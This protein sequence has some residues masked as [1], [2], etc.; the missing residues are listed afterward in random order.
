MVTFTCPKC[1]AALPVKPGTQLAVCS[2][3][4]TPSYIDRR[5]ALFFYILPFAIEETA[6]R[7]IF[8]RWTAGPACPKDMEASAS[9]LS[10]KKEYFPVFRF[11]RTVDGKEQVFSRPARGTL[12]PGMQ[13]VVIPPGDMLIFD[14]TAKAGGADVLHPDIAVDTYV[15]ELPG[16]P[17]D[18]SLVYF[19]IYEL[20]YRYGGMEYDLVIDGSS[21]RISVTN[22]PKRSSV[23]YVAVMV[24]SFILGFLG[25]LLG[26]MITPVFFALVIVGIFAGKILAHRVV[27]REKAAGGTA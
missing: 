21:G 2:F 26:F 20:K 8:K 19:P 6:A 5:E 23:S 9:V 4:G 1:G 12:L 25:V 24:L 7:G 16:T 14:S 18:Q 3:C 27:R 15:P 13:N 10:L 17:I 22:S 11:R